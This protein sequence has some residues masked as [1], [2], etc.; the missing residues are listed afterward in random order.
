[1]TMRAALALVLALVA[2]DVSAEPVVVASGSYPEG[3]LWHGGRMLFT[4]MGADQVSIIEGAGKRSFWH[5]AGC[6]PTS[7]AP[8]GPSG[9]LVT[10]HLGRHVVEV[11]ADG[12]T[13]RR[14]R[15]DGKG[16]PLQDPNA[17][18]GDG[19]GG[20][21][22][23]D[24]GIFHP[25]APATGRVY[26][27]SAMGVMTEVVGQ[28]QY[29]NG[30]A[31]DP[32]TRTLFVSEHLARRVLAFTLDAAQRVSAARMFADFAQ[33]PATRSFAYPLAG[34]D[35]IALRA[36]FVAI[37]EYGEG[38]VQVFERSG[39][40]RSTVKVAMPFV[41][42]VSFDDAGNLYAGG[43]FDNSRPPFNGLVV[44]IAPAEWDPK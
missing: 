6:G 34:P 20:A 7:I 21:Y 15:A 24:S 27:L 23:S 11:S 9:Y 13:G 31:F 5:D 10:C 16:N 28:L 42:T 37:A 4:E 30:V 14:F 22:F 19:Q 44:R 39:K 43:A 25:Q 35:G 40:H 12:A 17:S 29:A 2:A 8:F 41:D 33:V 18:T 36:G 3:L 26:H 1:M 32:Q 38:R